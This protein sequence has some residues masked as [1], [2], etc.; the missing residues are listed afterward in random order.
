MNQNQRLKRVSLFKNLTFLS[1]LMLMLPS[2]YAKA[3]SNLSELPSGQYLLDKSHASI[4]WKISHLG[5]SPYVA[6]FTDFDIDLNLN[7]EDLS[8][9]SISAVVNAASV[10]TENQK[11]NK[12]LIGKGW[13]K[14]ATY[15]KIT[16]TSESYKSSG[17]KTGKLAGSIEMFGIKKPVV[18]DVAIGGTV[19]S[20]P[21][22][23]NS[24]GV[25]FIASTTIKRSDWGFTK[26][27][28]VVGDEVT[29]EIA[30]EFSKQQD[31][32]N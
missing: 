28:S 22:I 13:F 10:S 12:D 19:D 14:T 20:H 5:L 15:P 16:F 24:V 23:A 21:F 32:N 1:F 18:F 11:F 8:K 9:S 17:D 29:I 2:Q 31:A 6:R 7:T 27:N 26:F 25:G 4:V 30:A 3:E